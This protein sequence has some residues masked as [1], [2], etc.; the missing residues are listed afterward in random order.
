VDARGSA[1]PRLCIYSA[2]LLSSLAQANDKERKF[3]QAE[4]QL[5]LSSCDAGAAATP[6]RQYF[7]ASEPRE[8]SWTITMI[9][10]FKSV[11]AQCW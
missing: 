2:N 9:R 7:R 10:I 4:E 11:G 3:K 8:Q 1:D 5:S 6:A